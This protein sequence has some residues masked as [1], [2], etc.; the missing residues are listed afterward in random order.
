VGVTIIACDSE[1]G[2]VADREQRGTCFVSFQFRAAGVRLMLSAFLCLSLNVGSAAERMEASLW[3]A[4]TM[5]QLAD[6]VTLAAGRKPV[7]AE[8]YVIGIVGSPEIEA[9]FRQILRSG[10]VERIQRRPLRVVGISGEKLA[11]E[12]LRVDLLYVA[13]K[14]EPAVHPLLKRCNEAGVVVIGETP[15]FT[16]KGGSLRFDEAR[17][18]AVY[19]RDHLSAG[20]YSLHRRVR[21]Y[22]EEERGR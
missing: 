4:W 11:G 5:A 3:K 2:K 10:S 6:Y 12:A 17:R 21:R 16:R 14:A 15:D 1:V 7:N 20:S 22:M 9:A 8:V 13:S 18:T 19:H